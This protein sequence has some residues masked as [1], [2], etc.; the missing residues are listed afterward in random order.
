MSVDK[1][2]IIGFILIGAVIM[3][4][5]WLNRPTPEQMEAMEAQRHYQDSIAQVQFAAQAETAAA[6]VRQPEI[7]AAEEIPD[8]VKTVRLAQTYGAFAAASEG[9][10]SFVTIEN[11]KVE[12]RVS[13]KGG[14][15]YSARLK[16]FVTFDKQPL[17]LFD[18]E[19]ESDFNLTLV[20]ATNRV[21]N[22]SELY[23]TSVE[24]DAHSTTMRLAIDGQ[25]YIDFIYSL[26]PDEYMLDFAIQCTGL[27]GVL[28]PNISS[29]DI[30]W[31]QKARQLEQGRKYENQ[32][33]GLYYKY[34]GDEVERL[35]E[36]K[37]DEER[38]SNRLKWIGFK[39]KFFSTVLIAE[40]A[41]YS[42]SMRSTVL[43]NANY[44]K[45][46]DVTTSVAFDIAG[47]EPIAFRY[48]IGPN[49]YAL[50]RDYDKGISGD[51][52]LT[53]DDLV[54]LGAKFFRP[55]NKYFIVPIFE[56]LGHYSSNYGLIIFLLTLIIKV[57]L[58]PLVYKSYMS[59]AK[60]RVLR[61]QVEEINAR[62]P[63]QEQAMDRQKATM[64]LYNRAGASPMSG[65]LPMLLQMPIWIALYGLF[66]TAFELRQSSFLW[67][68][69]LST[70]D[71]IISWNANIPL[72]NSVFGN[73]LSLFCILM[74]AV[75]IVYTKITMAMSDTGQQQM[76]GMK[77]MMYFMPV[78]M[79]FFFNQTSA[80]LSYYILISSLIT[81]AQTLSCR[82]FVNEEKLLLKLEENKKKPRKKSSFMQRLEEAQRKQEHTLK[83]QQKEK[84][85]TKQQQS[86][87]D[88]RPQRKK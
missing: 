54:P 52:A 40:D 75:Q 70:F 25:S 47:R 33:T 10:E 87:Q 48:F 12:L 85:R 24:S 2:T 62:Y 29:L 26:K 45:Q 53:L 49:K 82:F 30:N 86:R 4:F 44:L 78:M 79:F 17:I 28:S 60:M 11:E 13:T 43:D 27:N 71:D 50:L 38:T 9:E 32:Y 19:G 74:V 61:P 34:L 55:I 84:E 81:I 69:D 46:L 22:T 67:A 6:P 39:N 14:R 66:P 21:V 68:K 80:G 23:F 5:S 7:S 37:D 8:S 72:I 51:R 59:S 42:A 36:T 88:K 15:L 63:K 3:L 41:F 35:N 1:N 76:P 64:E 65:C 77:M 58:F 73:H 18:G 20:T 16:E 57:L 56:F 31:R 83:Q